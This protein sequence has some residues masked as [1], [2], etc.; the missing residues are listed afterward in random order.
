M[1]PGGG[2]RRGIPSKASSSKEKYQSVPRFVQE[3]WF[4]AFS[5]P[6][7]LKYL[8]RLDLMAEI[9]AL[10]AAIISQSSLLRGL[11]KLCDQ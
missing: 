2:G 7:D 10:R 5:L 8:Y 9:G 6:L 11:H 1:C 4:F 3:G